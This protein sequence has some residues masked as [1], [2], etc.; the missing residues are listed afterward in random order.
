MAL[1]GMIM[2]ISKMILIIF[3]N[4]NMST[5]KMSW[6]N[7]TIHTMLKAFAYVKELQEIHTPLE[8][9]V[10]NNELDYNWMTKYAAISDEYARLCL[11]YNDYFKR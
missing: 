3:C 7:L 8:S 11:N 1:Q 4:G 10:I 2:L 5:L 6:L 9:M